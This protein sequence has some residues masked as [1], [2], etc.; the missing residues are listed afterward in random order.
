MAVEIAPRVSKFGG[1]SKVREVR[2][3]QLEHRED[4][5]RR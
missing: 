3:K 1:R 4:P 2:L 5:V